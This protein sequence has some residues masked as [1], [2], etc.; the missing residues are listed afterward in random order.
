MDWDV[1]IARVAARNATLPEPAAAAAPP[2][3]ASAEA[4]SPAPARPMTNCSFPVRHAVAKLQGR[5]ARARAR[6]LTAG[7]WDVVVG[8]DVC[9]SLAS[10]RNL[11][12]RHGP[13]PLGQ[14]PLLRGQPYDPRRMSLAP[15][16]KSVWCAAPPPFATGRGAPQ[17]IGPLLAQATASGRPHSRCRRDCLRSTSHT[18]HSTRDGSRC[19]RL[20]DC[21]AWDLQACVTS[22]HRAAIFPRPS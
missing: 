10:R 6:Y 14:P 17:V 12:Q 4:R 1:V 8:P 21:G 22:C 15:R 11:K 20:R 5:F 7:L 18:I 16:R 3:P 2:S 13:Q 19:R 9:C